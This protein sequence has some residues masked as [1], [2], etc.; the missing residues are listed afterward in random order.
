TGTGDVVVPVSNRSHSNGRL[1][2]RFHGTSRFRIY[3]DQFRNFPIKI[4]ILANADILSSSSFRASFL[5]TWPFRGFTRDSTVKGNIP[6]LEW[7]LPVPN[8]NDS[9][10]CLQ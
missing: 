9:S 7:H 2:Q 3:R 8:I 10:Y 1:G 4:T 6:F 5:E